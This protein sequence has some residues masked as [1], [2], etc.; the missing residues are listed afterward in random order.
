MKKAVQ[1]EIKRQNSIR[2]IWTLML[3]LALLLVV[4]WNT[5]H[6]VQSDFSSLQPD[7]IQEQINRIGY[8]MPKKACLT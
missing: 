5:T 4:Y 6:V 1:N 7:K 3:L 2:A 8:Q